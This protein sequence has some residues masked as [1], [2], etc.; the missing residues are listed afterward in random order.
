MPT[1]MGAIDRLARFA[2]GLALIA[3][4]IPVGFAPSGWNWVGWVG[5]APLSTA[6]FGFCPLY[7]ILGVSTCPAKR[8]S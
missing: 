4:A 2:I 3:Y 8:A 7:S 6:V 5:L 1:N